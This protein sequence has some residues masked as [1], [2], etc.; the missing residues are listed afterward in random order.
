MA[1]TGLWEPPGV[2]AF[3]TH[4]RSDAKSPTDVRGVSGFKVCEVGQKDIVV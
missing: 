4:V 3:L 2:R 1:V